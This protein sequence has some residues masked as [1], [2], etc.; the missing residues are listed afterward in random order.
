MAEYPVLN[1][2]IEIVRNWRKK[3]MGVCDFAYIESVYFL[4]LSMQVLRMM[5][6]F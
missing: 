4:Q 6:L 1:K 2:L 3:V 5:R